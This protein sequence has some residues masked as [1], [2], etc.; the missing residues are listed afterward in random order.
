MQTL[1]QDLRY[2]LRLARRRPTLTLVTIFTLAIGVG[3]T[4]A[5]FSV[6]NALLLRPLPVP[7]PDRVVRVFGATDE[8][9]FD[10]LSYP[11]AIAFGRATTLASLAIHN[12]TRVAVGLGDSTDSAAA[13]LVSGN[14]FATLGVMPAL[15]RPLGPADDRLDNGEHVAVISD[16]WWHTRYGASPDVLGTSLFLNGTAFTIV[17]VA[18]PSFQGSYDAWSTDA[19]VPLMTYPVVRPRGNQIV[20]RGWGWLSATGRLAPGA[21]VEQADAELNTIAAALAREYPASS[22]NMRA[23]VVRAM[24]LPEEMAPGLRQVLFFALLVVG[25][26][27]GA[28]CANIANAQLAMVISRQREIAVRLAMGATRT[29]VLR[30]W[31]TES[32]V[33]ALAAT[34]VGLLIALWAR[35]GL[36]WLRPPQPELQNVS[37]DLSLDGRVLAFAVAMAGVTTIL[38]GGLPAVRAARSDVAT[39]LKDDG[40]SATGSRRRVWAQGTL[41]VAQVAVSLM[42]LVSAGL[43][44]RSLNAASRFDIGVDTRGLMLA[45]ASTSG[46]DYTPERTRAYY[47]DAVARLRALPGVADV[48]F[49]AVVP[50]SDAR[51]SRGVMIDGHTAPNGSRFISTASNIVATNYFDVMG[52]PITAGR[53]FSAAD[54]DDAAAPVAIVNETMARRYWSGNAVGQQIRLGSTTPPVEIVGV[55]RD[56]TYYSIGEAP[57]PYLYLPFGPTAGGSF[58]FHVRGDVTAATLPGLL[59]RELRAAD[60]RIRVPFALSYDEARLMPL[61]PSRAMAAISSMFGALALLLTAIGLYGVVMYTVS[62]RTREFAVRIALGASPADILRGVVRQGL[63]MAMIGVAI[64]AVGAAV[65]GRLLRGFLVGV[66]PL[67]PITF[68]GWS[69][70]IVAIALAAASLPARRATRIDPAA[71]L[72]GRS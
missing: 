40:I 67:D 36:M 11:N 47:R 61:Y 65:L 37:P 20:N 68:A 8:R 57:R 62:Q 52:I 10:V 35:E 46:L 44:V 7:D 50:L 15:G 54:G 5:T 60:P 21:S 41:V 43:L 55:A 48:T 32:V 72:T 56:I 17:G 1:L 12:Q 24:A 58:V 34:A 33:L 3:G 31:L 51:E 59:R 6:F 71:A 69:A 25:L 39:P 42:L 28:A 49:A 38:F 45:E 26:S 18:P 23:H 14:Y 63:T 16:R 27:L 2:A 64:G 30:Q 4:T 53:G 22:K 70:A 13:E 66:S 29:R 9:A 19:W